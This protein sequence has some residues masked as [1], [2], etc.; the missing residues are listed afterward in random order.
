[1]QWYIAAAIADLRW[2]FESAEC[3]AAFHGPVEKF[4]RL[5][6]QPLAG[7]FSV[8]GVLF[9]QQCSRGMQAVRSDLFLFF[10]SPF[11]PAASRRLD[12]G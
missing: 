4:S 11:A 3:D 2:A 5:K 1:M 12:A 7:T 6:S 8:E 10:S 9:W